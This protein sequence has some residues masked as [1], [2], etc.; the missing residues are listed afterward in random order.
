MVNTGDMVFIF[1]DGL[2]KVENPKSEVFGNVRL[3][4][5]ILTHAG[6]PAS[7]LIQ[8]VFSSADQFAEGR[9]FS[10]DIC[11]IGLEVMRLLLSKHKFI[12]SANE[13]SDLARDLSAR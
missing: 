2:C 7:K 1:T 13:T 10:D 8:D 3:R 4:E 6:V 11:I 12:R 5:A 9:P